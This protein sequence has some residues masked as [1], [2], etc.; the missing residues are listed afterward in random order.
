MA[1]EKKK[2]DKKQTLAATL[3]K[4]AD[5]KAKALDNAISQIEK[6]Y[7]KGT[8]M[9]L[10]Q[11]QTYE[12]DAI[13]TGSMTLDLALGIGGVPRGRIVEIY[14]PESSG[15]TLLHCILPLKHRSSA[16]MLRS[17]TLSMLL[18]LYMQRLS[19]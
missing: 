1:I 9:K 16:D 19:A 2:N 8:V 6:T 15:K 18:I 17:L 5:E 4:T 12:V 11:A 14:G 3:P 13:P 7:G 10:G